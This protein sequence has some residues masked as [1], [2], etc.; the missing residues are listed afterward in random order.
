[1]AGLGGSLGYLFGGVVDW[2][3]TGLGSTLG[4]HVQVWLR[5]LRI[6]SAG[7]AL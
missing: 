1:M 3:T 4:G 6:Q 5:L 2:Q 7:A